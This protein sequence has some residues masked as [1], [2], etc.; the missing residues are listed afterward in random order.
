MVEG[1][2]LYTLE[3]FLDFFRQIRQVNS[4]NILLTKGLGG[5][6]IQV[7]VSLGFAMQDNFIGFLLLIRKLGATDLGTDSVDNQLS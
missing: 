4:Q 1:K 3:I 5:L 6:D 7:L 2:T